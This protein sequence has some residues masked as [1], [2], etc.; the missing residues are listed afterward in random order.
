MD[1]L[2][3]CRQTHRVR[4]CTASNGNQ[5]FHQGQ[6]FKSIARV[7]HGAIEHG[8]KVVFNEGA[9]QGS[10]TENNGPLR[11]QAAVLELFEVLFHH[12]GALDQQTTHAD[13]IS[14]VLFSCLDNLVDGF[15]D[16]D[17][18]DVI[19]VVGQDDVDQVLTDVVHIATDGGQNDGSLASFV[20]LFHVR[21]E[22]C[23]GRLH[24]FS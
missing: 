9:G 6:A 4:I 16:A 15:L 20:A 17:V 7:A 19:T 2:L 11:A 3:Q 14:I 13:D 1:A 23:N 10:T 22:Q 21:L 8:S 5:R 12:H 18:D 24:D